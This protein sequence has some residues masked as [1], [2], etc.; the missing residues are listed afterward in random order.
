M[1][2]GNSS[3]SE[4]SLTYI[5]AQAVINS[6]LTAEHLD[7]AKRYVSLACNSLGNAFCQKLQ[8]SIEIQEKVLIRWELE[9]ILRPQ[10]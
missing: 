6:C 2:F 1:K 4:Q 9:D 7:S 8:A 10:K 5:K 3:T